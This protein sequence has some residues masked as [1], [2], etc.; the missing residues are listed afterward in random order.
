[1]VGLVKYLIA[2]KLNLENGVY[3]EE[4]W[5]DKLPAH[6]PVDARAESDHTLNVIGEAVDP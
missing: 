3:H 1:V 4:D 6:S 2:L 5:S